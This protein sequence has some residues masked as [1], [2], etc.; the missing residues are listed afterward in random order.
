M[1]RPGTRDAAKAERTYWHPE[2][3]KA[4]TGRDLYFWFFSFSTGYSLGD[5]VRGLTAALEDLEITSYMVYELLGSIDLVARCYV[6]PSHESELSRAIEDRLAPLG[7]EMHRPFHV[8]AVLHDWVWASPEDDALLRRPVPDALRRSFPASEVALLNGADDAS[9][10]RQALITRYSALGLLATASPAEGIQFVI[11]IGSSEAIVDRA[12]RRLGRRVAAVLSHARDLITQYS[13]YEGRGGQRELFL[14][15]CRC[16]YHGFYRIRD[17]LL[18][19]IR[20]A[21]TSAVARVTVYPV[22]TEDA[23]VFRDMLA[24]DTPIPR[25]VRTLLEGPETG[26]ADIK[27]SLLAPLEPWLQS[28]SKLE[29]SVAHALNGVVK[30]I[31]GL[32]NAGGGTVIIGAVERDRYSGIKSASERLEGYPVIGQY[33]IVGLLDPSYSDHG[34][35]AWLHKLRGLIAAKIDPSPGVLVQARI[36]RFMDHDVCVIR[37]DNPGDQAFYLRTARDRAD[38]Y[39]RLGSDVR[40]LVGSSIDAHREQARTIRNTR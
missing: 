40:R 3:H 11:V 19:P 33:Q 13:L 26:V 12:R 22:A 10:A 34:G 27:G 2:V 7:L 8:D 17:E 18:E 35:D 39:V 16:D 25:D 1:D 30:A 15:Q 6:Q 20:E 23:L 14:I 21:I 9:A 36:E 24:V 4:W 29:E 32:L 5:V 31:V 37:V 38:Y 28:G